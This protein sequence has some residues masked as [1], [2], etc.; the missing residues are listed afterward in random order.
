MNN[1]VEAIRNSI[2]L[3]DIITRRKLDLNRKM[4]VLDVKKI[5][6]SLN[7]VYVLNV[8]KNS[9]NIHQKDKINLLKK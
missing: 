9:K 8:E 2:K 6:L 4:G 3:L 7:F 5:V 1:F